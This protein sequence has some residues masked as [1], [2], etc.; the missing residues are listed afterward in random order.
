MT[1]RIEHDPTAT[2]EQVD[3]YTSNPDQFGQYMLTVYRG[4][5]PVVRT[6]AWRQHEADTWGPEHLLFAEPAGGAL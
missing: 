2:S 3:V 1:A 4:N 6:V 5:G